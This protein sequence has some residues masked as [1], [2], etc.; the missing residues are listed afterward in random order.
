M[1]SLDLSGCDQLGILAFNNTLLTS[2]DL[3]TN[4][5]IW[6]VDAQE[7]PYLKT[8]YLSSERNYDDIIFYYDGWITE[9][10]YR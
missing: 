7:N 5:K 10:V 3:T 4:L 2:V 8:I 9:L 1:T 6:K